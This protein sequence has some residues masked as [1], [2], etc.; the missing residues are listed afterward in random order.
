M[1]PARCGSNSGVLTLCFPRG[2]LEECL[3]NGMINS[4]HHAL[5]PAMRK[6]QT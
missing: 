1:G 4:V 5:A 6:H 2:C 3:G